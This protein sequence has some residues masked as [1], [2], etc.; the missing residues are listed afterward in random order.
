MRNAS[1]TLC[2]LLFGLAAAFPAMAELKIYSF[3]SQ[4]I[5]A[6]SPQLKSAQA[7]LPEFEKRKTDLEADAKK[8]Q[9]DAEKFQ[10][11]RD[12]M[13]PDQVAKTTKDLQG[14]KVDIDYKGNQ[15]QE[16]FDKRR[17]E[18]LEKVQAAIGEAINAIAK[19]K[20]ADLV[21]QDPAYFSPAI[22]VTDEVIKRLQANS[23]P[24]APLKP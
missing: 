5:L 14:R 21:V 24:P 2:G 22:D 10:K 16:E 15:L 7:Q 17:R 23:T 1:L 18:V 19:E 12:M 13:S 3:R 8:L 11:E 20:G 4:P 6:A 9:A